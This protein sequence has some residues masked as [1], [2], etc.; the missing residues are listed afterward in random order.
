MLYLD[1]ELHLRTH[2]HPEGN[3]VVGVQEGDAPLSFYRDLEDA[4]AL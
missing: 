1:S 2:W 3:Q 4:E